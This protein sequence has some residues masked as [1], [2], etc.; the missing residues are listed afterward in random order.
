MNSNEGFRFI[1]TR[2]GNT[3]R[4]QRPL[5][6]GPVHPHTHGEHRSM[7]P[8]PICATGSSPHAWGTRFGVNLGDLLT[9][10]I[11]TRMGNT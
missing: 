4:W 6:V 9:R 5:S 1:P 7:R 8:M 3:Y 2:M 11:P 10:F